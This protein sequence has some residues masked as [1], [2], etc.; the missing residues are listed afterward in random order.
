MAR[1]QFKKQIITPKGTFAY[2]WLTHGSPDLKFGAPGKYKVNVV[3]SG[4]EAVAFKEQV[5]KIKDEALAYLQVDNPKLQD[6]KIPLDETV[7]ENGNVVPDSWTVKPKANAAFRQPDG[8]EQ[9]NKLVIVD[10]DKK[11]ME[12]VAIWSGT[13]GKVAISVG[14]IDS[15]VYKGLV[16]RI[17]AVQVLSLVEGG[18]GG[19]SSMFDREDGFKA[20]DEHTA[21]PAETRVEETTDA[22]VD[23]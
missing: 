11:P 13:E 8:T 2:P 15:G 4:P 3:I 7:D 20:T 1:P 17:A 16:F 18:A 21:K 10:S 14:A 9:P 12:N 19:A 22:E 23:F 5:D 6:L